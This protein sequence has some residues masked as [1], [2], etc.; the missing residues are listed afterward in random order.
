MKSEAIPQGGDRKRKQKEEDIL[1]SPFLLCDNTCRKGVDRQI[2]NKIIT[3]T[4][5]HCPQ[6]DGAEESLRAEDERE[7]R[8]NKIPLTNE[9]NKKLSCPTQHTDPQCKIS[10]QAS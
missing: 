5:T 8:M 4:N 7:T 10:T 1:L 3:H 9:T 2:Q 6:D